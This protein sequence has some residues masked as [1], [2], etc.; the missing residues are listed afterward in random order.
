MKRS[1]RRSRSLPS[2]LLLLSCLL[3]AG[4][5]TVFRGTRQ[6]VEVFT[7]PPGATAIAGE[8][9]ITTPGVLRLDRKGK[10]TVV[11]IEKTGYQTRTATLERRADPIVW[12]NSVAIPAG[13]LAGGAIGSKT[14]EGWLG[15]L[16]E[17]M[18]Y[19]GLIAPA[20]AFATDYQ[21]GAAYRLVPDK[22]VV[23]LEP[24]PEKT[25]R[26]ATAAAPQR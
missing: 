20:A 23:K 6:K 17:G 24:S 11:R 14:G 15:D 8:Q 25:A 22:L 18:V 19:G 7:D 10:F 1:N 9:R 5:A 2:S 3:G 26:G 12:L 16:E 4:C 21:T 13:V